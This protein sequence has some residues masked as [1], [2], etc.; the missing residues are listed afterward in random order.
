MA[1]HEYPGEPTRMD[2]L[3]G[4][5]KDDFERSNEAPPDKTGEHDAPD[6]MPEDPDPSQHIEGEHG[7]T[8]I[9]EEDIDIQTQPLGPDVG[10]EVPETHDKVEPFF[11]P[12]AQLDAP[13]F[14]TILDAYDSQVNRHV[15]PPKVV[16]HED[17]PL[18]ELNFD[19]D[20]NPDLDADPD[21]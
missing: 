16:E 11:P 17:D 18:P 8:P 2:E 13:G 14:E 5:A 3:K 19:R 6:P 7:A 10:V 4:K 21:R 9:L 12:P 1:D 20:A 15:L